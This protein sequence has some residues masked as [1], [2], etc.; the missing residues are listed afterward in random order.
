MNGNQLLLKLL[1]S[2]DPARA[3]VKQ[4]ATAGIHARDH[5]ANAKLLGIKAVGLVFGVPLLAEGEKKFTE[6]LMKQSVVLLGKAEKLGLEN[7]KTNPD[8]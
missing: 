4:A 6:L 1:D 5:A 7:K 8:S 2:V 3:V